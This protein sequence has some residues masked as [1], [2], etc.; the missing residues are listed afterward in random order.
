MSCHNVI[1]VLNFWIVLGSARRL[2]ID[3][4]RK[5]SVAPHDG[6][7]LQPVRRGVQPHR[8]MGWISLAVRVGRNVFDAGG[9]KLEW[10]FGVDLAPPYQARIDGYR[11][12]QLAVLW[13]GNP[14][15]A[16]DPCPFDAEGV[17]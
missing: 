9:R 7:M 8:Q 10:L 15:V 5:L 14:L 13:L 4:R 16:V 11:L 17:G 2:K 1:D 12:D 6:K 3:H